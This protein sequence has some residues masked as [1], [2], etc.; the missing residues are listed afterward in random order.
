[1]AEYA[2]APT[3]F[4]RWHWGARAVLIGRLTYWGPAVGGREGLCR[5]F[6]ILRNEL[7]SAMGPCGVAAVANA[8]RELLFV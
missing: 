6:E 5:A 7:D 8:R 1:M 4:A 3:C 2:L